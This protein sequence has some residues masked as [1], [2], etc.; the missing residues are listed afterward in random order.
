M[1]TPSILPMGIRNPEETADLV[2]QAIDR[3]VTDPVMRQRAAELGAK[4]RAENGICSVVAIAWEIE[5]GW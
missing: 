5:E 1:V 4:I 2:S 3:A